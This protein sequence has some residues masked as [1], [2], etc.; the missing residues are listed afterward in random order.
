MINMHPVDEP[1]VV[2]SLNKGRFAGDV[3]AYVIMDGP[4]YFGHMLFRVDGDVTQ[5]L[6][7]GIRHENSLVDGAVRACV[8]AGENAG[9]RCFSL[10]QED[11]MLREWARVFVPDG[12]FPADNALVFHTCCESGGEQA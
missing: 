9:A 10:N 3:R 11:E 7:C 12:R 5:V 8:A 1:A 4:V 6:E 2:D